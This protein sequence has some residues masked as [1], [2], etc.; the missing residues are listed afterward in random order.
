MQE[1]RGLA[2]PHI[3]SKKCKSPEVITFSL[4]EERKMLPLRKILWP[5]DFSEASY[6]SLEIVKELASR[7]SAE[8]WAAYVVNPV[9]AMAA[10]EAPPVAAFGE[11]VLNSADELLDQA[12]RQRVG[13]GFEVH[14]RVTTGAPAQE[15]VRIAN[16]ENIDLIV[17][18]T[19]GESGFHHLVFGSVTEKVIRL[20]S[21]PVLVI[22]AHRGGTVQ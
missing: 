3:P 12:V 10:Y 18:A 17:I 22:R 6:E 15:I 11:E 20:A 21:C 1:R 5:T 19:H 2:V 13:D 4:E 16:E 7:F 14:T 8:L 9:P